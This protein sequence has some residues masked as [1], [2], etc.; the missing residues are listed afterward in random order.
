MFKYLA[1]LSTE[2]I[3]IITGIVTAIVAMVIALVI[4]PRT[5][6]QLWD[7]LANDSGFLAC[8]GKGDLPLEQTRECLPI[9]LCPT[10]NSTDKNYSITFCPGYG[11]PVLF[12]ESWVMTM[13]GSLLIQ[14]L[15]FGWAFTASQHG[16]R[17]PNTLEFISLLLPVILSP[18]GLIAF[19]FL[20]RRFA[21]H[22]EN[23]RK[24]AD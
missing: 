2:K 14:P 10:Q 22:R 1:Q 12:A 7:R 6:T 24:K 19:L 11:Y 23:E 17:S 16:Y 21:R 13:I 4:T 20:A 3:F 9:Y 8:D 15:L 5:D 18:Y